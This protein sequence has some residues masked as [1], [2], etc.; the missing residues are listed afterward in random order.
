MEFETKVI[1]TELIEE[2][3][4][5]FGQRASE[6]KQ[7]FEA[8]KG[9]TPILSRVFADDNKLNNKLVNDYR[10][11]IVDTVTGYVFGHPINRDIDK[12]KYNEAAY[13]L[14]KDVLDEFSIRNSLDDVDSEVGKMSS[15]CGY[16]VKL[17]YI[18]E[19]GEEAVTSLSP[20]ECIFINGL[21]LRHY[22]VKDGNN[23]I[24]RVEVYDNK[25]VREYEKHQVDGDFVLVNEFAHLFGAIPLIKYKN[26]EEEMG[27]FEKVE[28]LIDAYERVVSD[29][30][31][32]AEE[33]R[34]AYM[35]YYGLDVTSE[36]LKKARQTGG[37]TLQ[38]DEKIE[39]LTKDI[40]I[41]FIKDHKATLDEN[42]YKFAKVPNL[43]DE[44]F[45]GNSSGVSLKFKLQGL[46]NKAIV[47]ERK[48]NSA[49]RQMYKALQA[50]WNAKGIQVHYIDIFNTFTRN[51]PADIAAEAEL[52][53]KLNGIVSDE[54][55]LG[56]L[57][58]VDDVQYELELKEKAQKEQSIQSDTQNDN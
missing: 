48:F 20:W 47:K 49:D 42:I 22:T 30:Q 17:L 28:S 26:N 7:Q 50:P 1:N 51:L 27:D 34:L 16:G 46:E 35:L 23:E 4:R 44:N 3:I 32:E 18:N 39:F 40:N 29:V 53:A 54:T 55:L 10:G 56:M 24:K 25:F 37:F 21:A 11:D 33:L 38:E 8:Y 12:N 9:K 19:D 13:D 31:N 43:S 57:S 41:D 52:A 36:T 58:I 5:E 15:I 6:M 2:L 45:A 14:V